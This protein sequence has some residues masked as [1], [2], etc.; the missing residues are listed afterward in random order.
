MNLWSV[1]IDER[2]GAVLG[3]PVPVTIPSAYVAHVS[4]AADGERMV[5]AQIQASSNLQRIGFD[6]VRERVSTA[7]S[8]VTQ[9]SLQISMHDLSPD[10]ARLVVTASDGSHQEGLY[11][12]DV[13]GTFQ[14]RLT[15]GAHHDRAPR[16]SPDGQRIAFF[17]D[18]S[19]KYEIWT[20]HPDGSQLTQVTHTSGGDV[21]YPI[22][23]PDSAR[24]LYQHRGLG[25]FLMAS[26]RPWADQT[27]Q[28]LAQDGVDIFT[29]W[30]W[31]PDGQQLV[32]G[33]RRNGSEQRSLAT[34]HL[35]TGQ[36]KDLTTMGLEPAVWLSDSRRVI[37]R[38]RGT[39]YL[40]D[41][42]TRTLRELVSIAPDTLETITLAA[43]NRTIY[44]TRT[45]READIWLAQAHARG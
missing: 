39:L 45:T 14:R 32:G 24:L 26:D 25:N 21:Y 28:R 18:R 35:A 7:P 27:P 16:W 9:G 33:L 2:T 11:V 36:Y 17:S 3:R 23:S 40:L 15:D 37:F 31:S 13:D 38:N 41:S 30:A 6:P 44:F 42:A 5:Y 20:V 22:W 10:G 19:G 34:Y 12:F 43:D 1:A 29:P 4:F 8:F